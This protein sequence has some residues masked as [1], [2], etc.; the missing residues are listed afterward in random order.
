[1]RIWPLL[2]GAKHRKTTGPP[3]VYHHRIPSKNP[4]WVCAVDCMAA[5]VKN[6]QSDYC[7]VYVWRVM[8][9]SLH[10]VNRESN[11]GLEN[12]V[13]VW[14]GGGAKEVKQR[15]GFREK[16]EKRTAAT[17]KV[18]IW[19]LFDCKDSHFYLAGIRKEKPLLR[20]TDTLKG[21]RESTSVFNAEIL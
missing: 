4:I 21:Q 12:G 5:H 20:W 15:W 10:W 14:V 2:L 11:C 18:I 8:Q 16:Q 17:H 3:C 19:Q 6:R 9:A 13:G 1:M 7:R